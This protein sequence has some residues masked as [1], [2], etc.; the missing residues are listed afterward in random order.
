MCPVIYLAEYYSRTKANIDALSRGAISQLPRRVVLRRT[1]WQ[2]SQYPHQFP[3]D[4]VELTTFHMLVVSSSKR[5]FASTVAKGS[6]ARKRE[7]GIYQN[8]P[9]RRTRPDRANTRAQTPRVRTSPKGRP[10]QL[11][12]RAGRWRKAH[13]GTRRRRAL[14][15][16]HEQ[17][18]PRRPRQR[19]H[20]VCCCRY[21]D[22]SLSSTSLRLP[23]HY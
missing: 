19:W 13:A 10:R 8:A 11:P 7:V 6:D 16:L 3:D 1:T 9:R 17:S 22:I 18:H 14:Q 15:F 20:K 2:C 5:T 12:K 21:S 23:S 4:L